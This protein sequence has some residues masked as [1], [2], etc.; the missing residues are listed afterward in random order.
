MWYMTW[1]YQYLLGS[2]SLKGF[3][4]FE[5]S[6]SFHSMLS[7]GT[8]FGLRLGLANSFKLKSVTRPSFR[9]LLIGKKNGVGVRRDNE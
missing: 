1:A 3:L 4:L 5:V 8:T 7:Y 6:A 9:G 2:T